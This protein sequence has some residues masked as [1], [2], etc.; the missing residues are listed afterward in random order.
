M[1]ERITFANFAL[2]IGRGYNKAPTYARHIT[3]ALPTLQ[4]EENKRAGRIDADELI[5]EH[6]ASKVGGRRI[7]AISP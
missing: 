2:L 1:P 4:R 3:S 5:K 7:F 6:V